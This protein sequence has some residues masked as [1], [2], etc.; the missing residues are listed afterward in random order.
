[1]RHVIPLV[2]VAKRCGYL[3]KPSAAAWFARGHAAE[4]AGDVDAARAAYARAVA[5]DP[6]HREGN[7]NLGRL[8]HA[9]GN[10]AEAEAYYRLALLAHRGDATA[11]FNLGVAMHDQGRGA[12]AI[13]AYEEAVA[14]DPSLAEAHFNLA[15]MLDGR[16]DLPSQR[17]ALRHLS[18][19]RRLARG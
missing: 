7:T 1:M 3:R 17:A 2:R 4:L 15:L 5:T 14:L 19:Y 12:E 16:P 18:A 8:V 9:A 10:A 6:L 13:A 11:W